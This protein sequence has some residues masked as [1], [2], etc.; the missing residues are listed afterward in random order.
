MFSPFPLPPNPPPSPP[1]LAPLTPTP[2]LLPVATHPVQAS[3]T[4]RAV[5][6]SL[7][8]PNVPAELPI[9]STC[10][11]VDGGVTPRLPPMSANNFVFEN[12]DDKYGIDVP[13]NPSSRAS[14]GSFSSTVSRGAASGGA[15]SAS[16]GTSPEKRSMSNLSLKRPKKGSSSLQGSL[17]R[18]F[19]IFGGHLKYSFLK[20]G[21]DTDDLLRKAVQAARPVVSASAAAEAD[22]DARLLSG[23]GARVS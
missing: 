10:S 22:E 8:L 15:V 7:K 1:L 11:V 23:R 18:R 20:Y 19:S 16:A 9:A 13:G 17:H 21:T 4:T 14:S 2:D 5:G 6:S 12:I 3:T